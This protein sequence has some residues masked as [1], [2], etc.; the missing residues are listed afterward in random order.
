VKDALPNLV[1]SNFVSRIRAIEGVNPD[2]LSLVLA[3]L[4]SNGLQTPHSSQTTGIQNLDTESYFQVRIPKRSESE[5]LECILLGS[6]VIQGATELI[7]R[8]EEFIRLTEEFKT[9]LITSALTGQFDVAIRG[10]LA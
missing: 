6:E 1:C 7:A 8:L 4:Y 2:Y 3:S 5:Q 9:S 10:G